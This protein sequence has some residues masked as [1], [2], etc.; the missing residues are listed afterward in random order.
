MIEILIFKGNE[1]IADVQNIVTLSDH[2]ALFRAKYFHKARENCIIV[3]FIPDSTPIIIFIYVKS[4]YRF[5]AIIFDTFSAKRTMFFSDRSD[6]SDESDWSAIRC[7]HFITRLS[8]NG[9]AVK[10]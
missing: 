6:L 9:T 8:L 7:Y 5:S 2:N 4:N 10:P 3:H 1:M